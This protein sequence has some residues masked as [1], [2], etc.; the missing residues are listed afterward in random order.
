M[1]PFPIVRITSSDT[2][3][4]VIVHLL[5]VQAV[6][7]AQVTVTCKGRG[8]PIKICEPRHGL[9]A[10]ARWRRS[11]FRGSSARFAPA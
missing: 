4:G 6:A 9:H 2:A 10:R 11:S 3:S 1:R 8:C 5:R 7:G